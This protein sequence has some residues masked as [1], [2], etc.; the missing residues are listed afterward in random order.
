M[1]VVVDDRVLLLW[2]GPVVLEDKTGVGVN[3]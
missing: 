3:W 1:L 2:F